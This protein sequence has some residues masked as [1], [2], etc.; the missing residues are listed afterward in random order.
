MA[1]KE[2]K[3]GDRTFLFDSDDVPEG[4]EL[5]GEVKESVSPG[6]FEDLVMGAHDK[7]SR[8]ARRA[9]NKAAPAPDN[10]ADESE[11]ESEDAGDSAGEDAGEPAGDDSGDSAE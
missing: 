7:R 2:Y 1:L 5:V 6:S 11:D 3:L 10:K 4:A 9:A 8:K